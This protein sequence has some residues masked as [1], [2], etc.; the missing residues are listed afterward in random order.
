MDTRIRVGVN[1]GAMWR[2]WWCIHTQVDEDEPSRHVRAASVCFAPAG[3]GVE[4]MA[5]AREVV[6]HC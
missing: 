3:I 6:V 4:A 1:D 5:E 2:R